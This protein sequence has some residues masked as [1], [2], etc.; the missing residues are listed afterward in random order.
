MQ[1]MIKFKLYQPC[2]L[3]F[4]LFLILIYFKTEY[5][6]SQDI[7]KQL[8]DFPIKPGTPEWIELNSTIDKIKACQLPESVIKSVSTEDLL[9]ICLEYPLL[10]NYTASNSPY[11][12]ME[13]IVSVFNGLEEFVQ[14]SDAPFV[15]FKYYVAEDPSKIETQDDKG[16]YTFIFMALELLLCNDKIIVGFSTQE[17]KK[18]LSMVLEKYERKSNYS[19]YFGFLGKMTTAFTGIRYLKELDPDVL[20]MSEE[21]A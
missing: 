1:E 8:Y 10:N 6:I 16:N 12:G 14:R 2:K 5:A 9:L 4:F 20:I 11:K 3:F 21:E 13:N 17:K 19:D 7:R 15:L 18:V